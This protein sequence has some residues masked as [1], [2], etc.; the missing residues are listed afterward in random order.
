M[1]NELIKKNSYFII[2]FLILL[3]FLLRVPGINDGFWFDEWSSFYYSNPQNSLIENFNI[4]SELEGS[5]PYY[6]IILTIWH[7]IFGYHPEVTRMFSL[8]F[9][10]L[11]A[12]V[13]VKLIKSINNDNTFKY[14][15]YFLY[16]TNFFLIHY[17]E[18]ARWYSLSEFLSLLSIYLFLRII[19]NNKYIYLSIVINVIA[20]SVN[21]FAGLILFSQFVY[22]LF[23]KINKRF[24]INMFFSF[25]FIL[26]LNYKFILRKITNAHEMYQ[27]IDKLFTF[28]FFTGFYFNNFFGNVVFGGMILILIAVLIIFLKFKIFENKKINFFYTV[29]ASSYLVPIIYT[30]FFS[31]ILRD[32][33][34]IFIVPLIII[35]ISYLVNLIKIENFKNSIFFTL[36]LLSLININFHKVYFAKAETNKSIDIIKVSKSNIVYTDNPNHMFFNYLMNKKYAKDNLIIF[37]T[38]ISKVKNFWT[39]CLN[40]P[41]FRIETQDDDPNC[42]T[43]QFV[44]SHPNITLIDKKKVQDYI[45]RYY[46]KKK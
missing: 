7:D 26:I 43:N 19:K 17:T 21:F 16:C 13:F 14:L 11:S 32:R 29:I 34:I 27:H 33:Y 15:A 24:L 5:Q 23:S 38:D 20:V 2:I 3:W 30:L 31:P 1:I 40:N 41:R 22:F 36:I 45:L 18:E 10:I 9:S 42:L 44:N 28:E 39:F 25:I 37:E 12:I 8:F 4:V 46:T 35:C 6:F